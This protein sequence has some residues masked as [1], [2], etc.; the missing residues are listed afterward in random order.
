MRLVERSRRQSL[1]SSN[2]VRKVTQDKPVAL[3]KEDCVRSRSV[4]STPTS[5][6]AGDEIPLATLT[7]TAS[8]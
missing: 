8:R 1:S 3:L 6:R 7:G 4:S 5:V 2:F